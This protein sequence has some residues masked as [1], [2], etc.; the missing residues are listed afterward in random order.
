MLVR[1]CRRPERRLSRPG[2][3]YGAEGKTSA[4]HRLSAVATAFE[5]PMTRP[6]V[7]GP[8]LYIAFAKRCGS[9]AEGTLPA[10]EEQNCFLLF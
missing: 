1:L 4:G 7:K 2:S 8:E 6:T 5:T 10:A 9:I 3:G